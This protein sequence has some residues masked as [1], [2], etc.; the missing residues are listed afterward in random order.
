MKIE[1]LKMNEPSGEL[2][3]LAIVDGEVLVD[4]KNFGTGEYR[5]RAISQGTEPQHT[6]QA[7]ID[8]VMDQIMGPKDT[9]GYYAAIGSFGTG[10]CWWEEKT[11]AHAVWDIINNQ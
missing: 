1:T 5:W 2:R 6:S 8:E 10:A 9:D 7:Q 4:V 3:M 11:F